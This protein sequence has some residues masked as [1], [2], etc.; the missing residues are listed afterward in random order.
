[1]AVWAEGASVGAAISRPCQGAAFYGSGVCRGRPLFLHSPLGRA[2][3]VWA[4]QRP[5]VEG[6]LTAD[7]Q[8]SRV[9]GG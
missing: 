9:T 1:M 7:A 5:L 2:L 8:T 4:A 6:A 3:R